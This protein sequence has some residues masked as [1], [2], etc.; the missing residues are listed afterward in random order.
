MAPGATGCGWTGRCCPCSATHLMAFAMT[1][2][3]AGRSGLLAASPAWLLLVTA[4]AIGVVDAFYTPSSGSMPRRLVPDPALSWRVVLLLSPSPRWRS[5]V[6]R[7]CGTPHA[8]VRRRPEIASAL[9]KFSIEHGRVPRT[10]VGRGFG[11]RFVERSVMNSLYS[12]ELINERHASLRRELHPLPKPV[13]YRNRRRCS[14]LL[15]QRLG[16]LL[17]EIGLRLSVS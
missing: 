16:W 6:R 3:A 12:P 8:M 5:R 4:L 17:V 13:R 2:V 10:T 7:R 14:R 1:W 11:K 9:E 15:R